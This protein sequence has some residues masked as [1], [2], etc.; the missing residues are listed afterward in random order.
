MRYYVPSDNDVVK[1]LRKI[2]STYRVI[3]SQHELQSLVKKDLTSKK[4]SAGVSGGRIR[5]IVLRERIADIEI[6]TREGDPRK[7]LT[8]CPVCKEQLRRVKNQTIWGGEVTIEFR[9]FKCGYWT[10]KKKRVPTR[11]V[12]HSRNKKMK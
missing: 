7:S 2:F 10:G 6:R 3:Q 5:S 1:S 11:Y 8:R 4:L 12:F 9:C